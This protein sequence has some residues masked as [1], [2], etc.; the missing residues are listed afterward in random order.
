VVLTTTLLSWWCG[1]FM[2]GL[3]VWAGVDCFLCDVCI[4]I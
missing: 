4:I 1:V 2:G 3:G